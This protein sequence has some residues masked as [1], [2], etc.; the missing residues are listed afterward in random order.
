VELFQAISAFGYH[1]H[2]YSCN[3]PKSNQKNQMPKME[4]IRGFSFEVEWSIQ[5]KPI[6]DI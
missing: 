3:V 6:F 4:R 2:S 5:L 1:P